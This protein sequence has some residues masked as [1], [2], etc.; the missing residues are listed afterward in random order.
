MALSLHV[1]IILQQFQFT[2]SSTLEHNKA[3]AIVL[4]QFH[5]LLS[6]ALW[7]LMKHNKI[8]VML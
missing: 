3:L 7:S 4:Q 5:S 2:L 1:A 6:V 8:L